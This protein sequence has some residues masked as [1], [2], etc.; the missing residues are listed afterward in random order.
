MAFYRAHVLVCGGFPCVA[1]GCRAVRDAIERSVREHGL[2]REV[3]IVETGCL[4]PCDLGPI[5]VV[6]PEGT[7]YSASAWMM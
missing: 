5:V 2:E 7:V 1:A 6:Y 3:R 4:G